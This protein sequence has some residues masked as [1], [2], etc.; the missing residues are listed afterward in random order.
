MSLSELYTRANDLTFKCLAVNREDREE[1]HEL[2]I[3]Y[4]KCYHKYSKYYRK[5]DTLREHHFSHCGGK[6]K[7][8]MVL[9]KIE[10]DT[11]YLQAQ[12]VK[13]HNTVVMAWKK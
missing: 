12:V 1:I 8:I 7:R 13:E 5:Y 6:D 9:E 10:S 11:K 3:K 4:H 2:R